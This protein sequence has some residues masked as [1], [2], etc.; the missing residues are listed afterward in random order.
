M[1]A[2]AITR[3]DLERKFRQVAGDVGDQVEEARSKLVGVAVGALAL[4]VV[5]AY[6]VGRRRG[7]R[8][9]AVV[10]IRRL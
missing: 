8:K 4:A 10:E 2:G 7:R 9:S 5:A 3:D 1:M 6:L